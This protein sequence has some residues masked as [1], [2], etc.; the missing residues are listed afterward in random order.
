MKA[1]R[2]PMSQGFTLV[3]VLVA[4]AITGM[5]VSVLMSSL[6]YIFRVQEGLRNET[7]L[8]E[9]QLR[10][11]AWFREVLAGC[12][13]EEEESKRYFQGNQTEF[14]CETSNTLMPEALP[15]TAQIR[16]TL[17]QDSDKAFLRYEE[18]GKSQTQATLASWEGVNAE[19]RFIDAKGEAR[20][21]WEQGTEA[22][23]RQVWLLLTPARWNST[24]QQEIWLA[25][26]R[27]DPWLPEKAAL[28]P[29][30]SWDM[31]K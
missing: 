31:F 1:A 20:T 25:A 29:G 15:M 6:F 19:F 8:R 17:V 4:L 30:M 27:A 21:Q 10:E 24:R 7:M 12:L 16:M 22:L 14:Q 2:V 26:P 13:P 9:R 3:E 18:S 5:L 28:P 11:R 23:P